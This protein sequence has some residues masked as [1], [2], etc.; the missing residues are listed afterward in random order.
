MGNGPTPLHANPQF[1]IVWVQI[2]WPVTEPQQPGDDIDPPMSETWAAMEELV[3][4]VR[5]L[6]SYIPMR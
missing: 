3:D 4:E 1:V 2:H 5:H 6:P